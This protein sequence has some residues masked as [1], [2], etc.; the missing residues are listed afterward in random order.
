MCTLAGSCWGAASAPNDVR[1]GTTSIG[2][3]EAKIIKTAHETLEFAGIR[4][5]NE[6]SHVLICISQL[7]VLSCVKAQSMKVG[8]VSQSFM[9]FRINACYKMKL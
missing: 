7:F 9:R 6:I 4:S 3:G 5:L 2:R 1:V 8:Q